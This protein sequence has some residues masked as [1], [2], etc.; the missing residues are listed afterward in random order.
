MDAW[1]F[2]T[3]SYPKANRYEA[4]Q[5]ALERLALKPTG[6]A[7]DDGAYGMLSA[8]VSQSGISFT[9]LISTP[10]DISAIHELNKEAGK[11][12]IWLTSLLEGHLTFHDGGNDI[13]AT[14]G[15]IV[16]GAVGSHTTLTLETNCRVIIVYIPRFAFQ[17]RLMT[18]L[19]TK[20]IHLSG[21][22]GIGHVLAGF[23]SSVAEALEDLSIDQLRP[24]EMALPEFLMAGIFRQADTRALGGA[25]GVRAA[26]LHRVCQ[27][28][29][30]Q[31]GDPDLSLANI[32][33]AHGISPRYVQK[34]FESVGQSFIRYIRYRRLER[35]RYDLESPIH[36]QLSISDI[37]FRWGFNDAAH[38]SRAFRDQYGVSPREYR[39]AAPSNAQQSHPWITNRGRPDDRLGAPRDDRSISWSDLPADEAPLP[40]D[41]DLAVVTPALPSETLP[42]SV[43]LSE[44]GARHHYLPVTA[45]TVHWGYFSRFLP[46]VLEMNSGDFVTIET[47]TQHA[48]DDYE[49]MIE[50]DPGAE[51]VFHWTKD[52]KNVDRRGAGP[53]DASTYGRG[54][55]EGFGVHICTGPI[56]IHDAK[57][58]DIVE[59][60][61]L[62][63]HPRPSASARFEGRHFGS[64]AAA[65]W[66]YHYNELLTPP[67]PR[68]VI[69]IYEIEKRHGNDVARAVYNYRWTPQTDPFGVVH[70]L[71]DYPGVPVDHT[72]IEKNF[73]VLKSVEI[74]LRAHF[75]V[76]ALAPD[77]W[78]IVDSVPPAYFGGNIDNWRLGAGSCIFLPVS[79]PG[80]LLSVGDPHASQGDSELCGTAIECSLTGIFQVILHKKRELPGKLID[81]D[82]PLIETPDEWVIT[83][84]SHPNYLKELGKNAQTEVY[85]QASVDMAMRD[86]FRKTRRFLMTSKGL[87]EDEA[88]SLMSV[89]VDF[90]ITQVVD[91]NWGVHAVIRKAMFLD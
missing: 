42:I 3:E 41:G 9:R 40:E 69:T 12:G 33:E 90:G 53:M 18:P 64:N 54:P 44:D 6:H 89:G 86:A 38:F 82:Y 87:S 55:G 32:A 71:I 37:C 75:G 46:P 25:A 5:E 23:L 57:P 59:L 13:K 20:V 10:Q 19:P 47:L 22:A 48:Y 85:K 39:R 61:I 50:N 72:T 77:H 30:A 68:E 15:D 43:P 66:G 83:G 27:T 49:R 29:E 36:G 28:I 84:F 81:L 63:I 17:P 56:S 11:D 73:D 4:W 60:R 88:I 52:G 51:S 58:G 62:D 35:C 31:L 16:Y 79:V 14:A 65:W 8:V 74:P 67:A 1:R 24:I 91:G 45:N 70:E 26:L 7:T 2:S 78:G 34:L 80:G 76:V 21:R